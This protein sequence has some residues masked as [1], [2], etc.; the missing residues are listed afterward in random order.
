MQTVVLKIKSLKVVISI[1]GVKRLV[2]IPRFQVNV[3]EVP[4]LCYARLAKM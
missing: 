4:C 2:K 3:R 1:D